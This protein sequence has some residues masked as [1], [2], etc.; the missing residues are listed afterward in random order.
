MDQP[1]NYPKISIQEIKGLN[2]RKQF[3]N[4]DL[5]ELDI[6]RNAIPTTAGA[7]SRMNGISYMQN[8]GEPI[9]GFCQTNDSHNNIL[10]QTQTKL[11]RF[12]PAEFWG[13]AAFVPTLSPTALLEEDSMSQAIIVHQL[14]TTVDAATMAN[15]T[16]WQQAPLSSI[17][18]QVNPDGT[19]A[20]FVT[21]AANQF[22]LSTGIYRIRGWSKA[23]SAALSTRIRARLYNITAGAPAWNGA[24]NENSEEGILNVAGRNQKLEFGGWLNISGPTVFEIEHKASAG[25]LTSTFGLASSAGADTSKEIYRWIEILKTGG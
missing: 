14:A 8:L 2:E 20:A 24:A 1:D 4:Q 6:L 19:V 21:I 15:N 13:Q 11:Y 16:N 10:V 23:T 17:I 9:Y 25:T 7:L 22:T 18:Q 3:N 5:G 12:T